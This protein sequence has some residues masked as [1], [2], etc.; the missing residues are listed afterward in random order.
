MIIAASPS[1]KYTTGYR[2]LASSRSIRIPSTPSVAQYHALSRSPV[3]MY[4]TAT[5]M[6]C[7]TPIVIYYFQPP[8]RFSNQGQHRYPPPP[9]RHFTATATAST[10]AAA[11]N[12]IVVMMR[13]AAAPAEQAPARH[14]FF[15]KKRFGWFF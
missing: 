14:C 10:T 5:T 6:L 13:G 7:A 15:L 9:R 1:L 2:R 8:P 12:T 4:M 3:R 11:R